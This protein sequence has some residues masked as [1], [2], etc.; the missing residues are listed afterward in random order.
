MTL[1]HQAWKKV[2]RRA[3][4]RREIAAAEEAEARR[5]RD[6]PTYEE[7]MIDRLDEIMR[8]TPHS[9]IE[10]LARILKWHISGQE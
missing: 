7:Q 10:E 8:I 1:L 4:R 2:D 9:H 3:E 5:R 6:D